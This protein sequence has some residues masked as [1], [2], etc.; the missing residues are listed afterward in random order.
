MNAIAQIS[1][2]KQAAISARM[3]EIGPEA[4]EANLLETLRG[5]L[6]SPVTVES[7]RL[8]PDNGPSVAIPTGI[9]TAAAV[10]PSIAQQALRSIDVAFVPA[11]DSVLSTEL[12]RLRAVTAKRATDELSASVI[13]VAYLDGMR[14]Y[15][16]DIAVAVMRKRRQWW[17]TLD[18]LCSDA[19][20]MMHTRRLL[21]AEFEKIASGRVQQAVA[22]AVRPAGARKLPFNWKERAG[23]KDEPPPAKVEP[24]DTGPDLS[25]VVVSAA[26]SERLPARPVDS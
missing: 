12:V 21:R 15:P 25:P 4:V 11:P 8:F 6:G 14:Q 9:R 2:A 26:L 5:L 7:R 20:A 18:E 24:A 3:L 16:A 10:S 19:D 22:A 1:E 17:P 23:V 13:A